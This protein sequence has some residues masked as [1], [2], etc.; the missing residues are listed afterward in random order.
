MDDG[1]LWIM[2]FPRSY[3]V[4]E[5]TVGN[6]PPSAGMYTSAINSTPSRMGQRWSLSTVILRVVLPGVLEVA[7]K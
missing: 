3:G 1:T 5:M 4:R 6:G 2:S 7:K